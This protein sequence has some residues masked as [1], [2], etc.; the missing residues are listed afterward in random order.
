MKTAV[1]EY[2]EY[3]EFDNVVHSWKILDRLNCDFYF[4]T[5]N[6]SKQNNNKLGIKREFD[7]TPDMILKYYPDAVIDIINRESISELD[8]MWGNG[9]KIYYHWKNCLKLLKDSKKKYDF[10]L[11]IRPDLFLTLN[12]NY[13]L[14][15]IKLLS[16]I[17]K[18]NSLFIGG[19]IVTNN[20]VSDMFIL[21]SY[22]VLEKL[23]NDSNDFGGD[24]HYELFNY[25][26]NSKIEFI[27]TNLFI[28]TDMVRP[29]VFYNKN[30]NDCG[31]DEQDYIY[32]KQLEWDSTV[33][34][35]PYS[36]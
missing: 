29:N 23:I 5:W 10:I 34:K 22:D 13:T 18:K 16:K 21:G 2:G 1:L 19:D 8:D 3:R 25:I 15:P 7:V 27:H 31:F 4:S 12:K 30:I 36:D 11:I 28:K 35:R 9:I 24:I 33:I 14:F 20:M 26:N 32:K 17:Y 6:K